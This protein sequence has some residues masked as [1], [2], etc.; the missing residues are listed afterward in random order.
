MIDTDASVYAIGAVLLQQQDKTD[1]TL[2]A[3]IDY[4]SKT[5][6]KEHRNYSAT[7]REWYTV[8]WATLT[9]RSYIEGT[10]FVLRMDQNALLW[11]M[12]TNDP[13]GRLMRL[14]LRLMEFDYEIVY[15]P[16]RVH[17]VPDELSRLLR[18]GGADDDATLMRR[19]LLSETRT[20]SNP[21]RL[22]P[23]RFS[24]ARG[25]TRRRQ[26]APQIPRAKDNPPQVRS[27]RIATV[28]H[29]NKHQWISHRNANA[30]RARHVSCDRTA[31][32]LSRP[33]R[34]GTTPP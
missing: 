29:P 8:V 11:M 4:W 12:T 25:R 18:E 20:K 13:Q 5:L 23:S 31:S 9:L 26:S 2:W 33:R 27:G 30:Y 28:L 17:Q 14:R 21:S 32:R 1:P 19:Y 6:T 15:L 3:T 34:P 24:L 16:G 7:E 22:T 10:R